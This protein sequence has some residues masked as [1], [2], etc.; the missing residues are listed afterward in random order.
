MN[1]TRLKALGKAVNSDIITAGN[2]RPKT[3][4]NQQK[5]N[6]QNGLKRKKTRL[7]NC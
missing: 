4:L 7:K 3:L 5:L 6:T 1:Q 2:F